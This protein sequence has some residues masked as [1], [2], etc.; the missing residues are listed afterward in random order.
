[1]N[2]AEL[3]TAFL[4]I[5]SQPK[6]NSKIIQQTMATLKQANKTIDYDPVTD[7]DWLFLPASEVYKRTLKFPY[8]PEAI[9]E[10]SVLLGLASVAAL[11]PK[12]PEESYSQYF[13]RAKE[14]ISSQLKAQSQLMR[15]YA[16]DQEK[17]APMSRRHANARVGVGLFSIVGVGK[18]LIDFNIHM[19]EAAALPPN[20]LAAFQ[21]LANA[22]IDCTTLCIELYL[23]RLVL[24]K[25]NSRETKTLWKGMEGNE[26]FNSFAGRLIEDAAR[27]SSQ[28]IAH[29]ESSNTPEA[30]ALREEFSKMVESNAKSPASLS[31]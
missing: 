7:A 20:N 8:A 31:R 25:I 4:K 16:A 15:A 10:V 19:E 6:K 22:G 9:S 26:D 11:V 13:L 17:P 1:M 14:E 23:A 27:L 5:A 29:L 12:T 21:P 28:L 2:S 30:Q 24:D 18:F 3:A